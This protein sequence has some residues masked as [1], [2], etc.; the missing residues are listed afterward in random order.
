MAHFYGEVKGSKGEASRLGTASSGIG[1]TV[2]SYAGAI[3]VEMEVRDGQDWVSVE[4]I[5]WQGEGESRLLYDGPVGRFELT[6]YVAHRMKCY[7]KGR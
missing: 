4:M 3:R 1:A 7:L 2:A 5:P 6:D